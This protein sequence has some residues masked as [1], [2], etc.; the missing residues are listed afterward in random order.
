MMRQQSR[1]A[2]CQ[3]EV[4]VHSA[5]PDV[6]VVFVLER[7]PEL[8]ALVLPRLCE[9]GDRG[10]RQAGAAPEELAKAQGRSHRRNAH[11]E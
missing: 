9:L 3:A 4:E 8:L 10:R 2:T 1:F 11:A 5:D 7:A 6:H